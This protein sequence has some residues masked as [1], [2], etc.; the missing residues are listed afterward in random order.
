MTVNLQ[1]DRKSSSVEIA[2]GGETATLTYDPT[3]TTPQGRGP[4]PAS[5]AWRAEH[6]H[7]S[8]SGAA[9]GERS[10]AKRAD[11]VRRRSGAG[12]GSWRQLPAAAD[13]WQCALLLR[14]CGGTML[15]SRIGDA[16]PAD[17]LEAAASGW[18]RWRLGQWQVAVRSTCPRR[19]WA[20]RRARSPLTT[21]PL[22]IP[23]I[24]SSIRRD[25]PATTTTVHDHFRH[26]HTCDS[27]AHSDSGS[28]R[29]PVN[30]AG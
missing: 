24:W 12:A 27:P 4:C 14:K 26:D 8:H 3:M 21:Q 7:A 20:H 30:K 17:T 29:Q 1:P 18:E 11:D 13:R 6:G 2:K 9:H 5:R 25:R 28:R 15:P 22:R 10:I 16:S 19:I 23:K